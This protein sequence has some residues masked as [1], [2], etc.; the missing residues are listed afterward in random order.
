VKVY[1]DHDN[2]YKGK[3]LIGTGVQL[4][5]FNPLSSLWEA[6]QHAGI[7]GVAKSSTFLSAGSRRGLCCTLGRA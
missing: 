4:Q 5:M 1:H 6:W 7:H 3:Y 2:S